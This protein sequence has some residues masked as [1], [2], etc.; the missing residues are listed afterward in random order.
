MDIKTST[1]WRNKRKG[2]KMIIKESLL[3]KYVKESNAIENIFV[4]ENHHLFADHLEAAKL[5]VNQS[6]KSKIVSPQSIH[7]ILMRREFSDAGSFRT[8]QVR[9]GLDVKPPPGRVSAYMTR[10]EISLF[11]SFSTLIKRNKE[12]IAWYYHDW[13][14]AIHP[15]LDGNGRTGRLILN[16]ARLLLGL[17]WLIVRFSKREQY[18]E[19]IRKWEAEHKELFR[20]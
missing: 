14:E 8:L 19:K 17:P 18:Y 10:W 1:S 6:S 4:K 7:A 15:F 5:V 12:K 13:F 3:K 2:E 20:I 16:N 9:V 11:S